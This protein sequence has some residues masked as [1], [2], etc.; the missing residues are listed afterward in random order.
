MDPLTFVNI[1]WVKPLLKMLNNIRG[2]R[3]K[4]VLALADVFGDPRVML[5]YY[6]VPNCQHHNPG[7]MTK[8][9]VHVPM[10][11]PRFTTPCKPFLARKR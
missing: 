3:E 10:S 9:S 5:S 4:E 1:E 8:T 2:Q 11:K 7:I 6:V